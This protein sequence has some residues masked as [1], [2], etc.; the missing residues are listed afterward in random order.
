VAAG[1]RFASGTGKIPFPDP[2]QALIEASAAERPTGLI[3]FG[4]PYLLG[5]ASKLAA[6]LLAW[7]SNPLT[8]EAVAAALSGAPITG[9]LPIFLPAGYPIGHGVMKGAP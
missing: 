3:S 8:E 5:A 6:Y 4:T 7:T 2:L 1:I 9:H